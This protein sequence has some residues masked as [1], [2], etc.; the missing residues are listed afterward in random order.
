MVTLLWWLLI[1]ILLLSFLL[2][3]LKEPLCEKLRQS[4]A[5][6]LV[7]SEKIQVLADIEG[8]KNIPW[9]KG[10]KM[11]EGKGKM[12]W[13]KGKSKDRIDLIPSE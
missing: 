10:K 9:P 4:F 6:F 12:R 3:N 7:T 13:L 1:T 8:E 11:E 2:Q 5:F